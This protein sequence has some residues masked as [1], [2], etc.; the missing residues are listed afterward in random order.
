MNEEFLQIL[1]PAITIYGSRAINP[2]QATE[3]IIKSLDVA[4]TD[5]VAKAVVARVSNEQEGGPYKTPEDFWNYLE[6][7]GVKIDEKS[8]LV[9]L[10]FDEVT[11]FR[12]AATGTS[13]RITKSI[14]AIAM[15]FVTPAK[16]IRSA[17]EKEYQKNNPGSPTPTPTP[18]TG[19]GGGQTNG[20]KPENDTKAPPTIVYWSEH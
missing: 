19:P 20:Q 6:G 15:N 2:N 16:A 18:A 7:K 12:I 9:P 17:F 10:I 13:G 14:D 5:E 8:K 1:E 3:A 4:I 11:H